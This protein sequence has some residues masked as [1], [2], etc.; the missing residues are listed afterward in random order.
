M[1]CK[2]IF[3]DE[4]LRCRRCEWPSVVE[5]QTIRNRHRKAYWLEIHA[6]SFG[7]REAYIKGEWSPDRIAITCRNC[8]G[9]TVT[10]PPGVRRG[11]F[12]VVINRAAAWTFDNYQEDQI[13]FVKA[14]G[15]YRYAPRYSPS[16]ISRKGTG[17]LDVFLGPLRIVVSDPEDSV[18]MAL[19]R[20]FSRPST[21]GFE[22]VVH[23]QY[24]ITDFSRLPLA[25]RG[26]HLLIL[27][28]EEDS[29]PSDPYHRWIR[30]L[31]PLQTDKTGLR[32]QENRMK[33]PYCALQVFP[34]PI[35]Q[36]RSVLYI[37]GNDNQMFGHNPFLRRIVLP[38]YLNGIHPLWNSEGLFFM[39]NRFYR[40]PEWGMN[41][42][43]Y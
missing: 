4:M 3:V 32:Y 31:C 27:N 41:L 42:Q 16:V 13:P 11:H 2:K 39:N 38:S 14:R 15:G 8:T 7:K 22:P 30:S 20:Q 34:N 37:T 28:H 25:Y 12:Q 1:R 43:E 23:T 24:P 29:L 40:I 33:G 21:N 10:V 26:C 6:I 36:D 17:L 19:A 18:L 5:Y 35:D 9:F